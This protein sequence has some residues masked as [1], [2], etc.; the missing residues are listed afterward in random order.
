MVQKLVLC[1]GKHENFQKQMPPPCM[2]VSI[3]MFHMARHFLGNNRAPV[4]HT[5]SI[6][7]CSPCSHAPAN[8]AVIAPNHSSL[9]WPAEAT[10]A[11]G[12][13]PWGWK[14]SR[15]SGAAAEPGS[16]DSLGHRGAQEYSTEPLDGCVLM[17]QGQLPVSAITQPCPTTWGCHTAQPRTEVH[18]SKLLKQKKRKYYFCLNALTL[19]L[20]ILPLALPELL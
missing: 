14:G 11:A 6:I 16:W 8:P 3:L 19:T 5:A 2:K 17:V 4:L 7:S 1:L 10:R 13:S 12:A 20:L 9:C 15:G 18:C